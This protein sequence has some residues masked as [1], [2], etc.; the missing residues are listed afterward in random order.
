MKKAL[1]YFPVSLTNFES[2]ISK[3]CLGIIDAFRQK[4]HTDVFS[5]SDGMV[6]FNNEL[7]KNAGKSKSKIR[8]YYYNDNLLGQF[9]L[10]KNK[11]RENLYDV[12][13]IRFPGFISI[14]M[15]VFLYK[16]KKANPAIIINFEIATYPFN[17]EMKGVFIWIR[18]IITWLLIP[19]LRKYVNF[20]V[21]YS[22]DKEIWK[23]PAINISNGYYNPT[24]SNRAVIEA[25][26]LP[27][28]AGNEFNIAMVAQF[29]TWHAPDLLIE[30]LYQYN[31]NGNSGKKILLHLIGWGPNIEE[32]KKQVEELNLKDSV[33][34]YGAAG[35]SEIAGILKNVH[36]CVGTLGY[37]RKGITLGS[38]LKNR[39]YAFLGM[40][41]ILKTK[42]LDFPPSLFFVKYFPDDESL[43]NMDE[44]I[45]FYFEMR[46]KH[47]GYKKEIIQYA[48]DK[49]SWRNKLSQVFL[50]IDRQLSIKR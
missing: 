22:D 38:C 24:F 36:V 15:I 5:E 27:S 30:S 37:H 11:I 16:L 39:E 29:S 14:G 32:C 50:T 10:I 35:T 28:A 6:Y 40:P 13:Y 12:A 2:G 18:Y 46:E 49:L 1:L 31:K 9:R 33:I 19:V 20:I 21:T 17:K 48:N 43:L 34:F 41:I 7:I 42:D 3:K 44:V 26:N 4:Y 8:F 25:N 23:I 45:S 47:P